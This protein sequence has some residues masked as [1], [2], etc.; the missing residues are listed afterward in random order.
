M[1]ATPSSP[2]A[3]RDF[4][5]LWLGE[6]ISSLGD[7]FAL[8]ALPWLALVLT[9]SALALG[10]VLALMAVPRALLMLVGGVYVDRLSPRRVMLGSN[11]VRLVAVGVLGGLVFIDAAQLWMVYV[12]ALFFGIADAFFFP[13]QTSIVPE[14]VPPDQLQRANGIVQGT[15]QATVLIGPAVAGVVIVALGSSSAPGLPGIGT[16]LLVDAAS[17]LASLITLLLIASRPALVATVTPVTQ[18]IREGISFVWH[19]PALR[20]VLLITMALNLLIVG[21]YEVGLPVVAYSR[22][23]EGAAAFGVMMS[24]FGGGSLLGMLAGAMLPSPRPSLFGPLVI[25]VIA[26][27]G[28]GLAALAF[29][30]STLLAAAATGASGIAIGYTNLVVI[31]W[32]QLRIPRDLMGRVL[33]LLGLS[34]VGLVPVSEVV[35]GAA[36]QIS[37]AGLLL[38]SGLAMTAVALSALLSVNIRR[39]GMEPTVE[40]SQAADQDEATDPG[41]GAE[42]ATS[43]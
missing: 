30:D 35:A 14:L 22:L 38:V 11:A 39:M 20:V 23:P 26:T 18:A 10:S 28:L 16:A 17:F 15:A 42:A 29:I 36:V 19:A 8:I 2:F 32:A 4:R 5:L 21:P 6:A 7:Q 27:S 3:N 40:Q 33:S 31:T 37:L 13:A 9:G 43:S 41:R 1:T 24:A 12:F 34:S 25:V